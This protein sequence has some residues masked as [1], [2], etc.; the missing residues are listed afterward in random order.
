[1]TERTHRK[2]QRERIDPGETRFGG[3]V[4]AFKPNGDPPSRPLQGQ[5]GIVTLA[6]D[7]NLP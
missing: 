3:V 2:M 7:S 6:D 5:K 4:N 1:M